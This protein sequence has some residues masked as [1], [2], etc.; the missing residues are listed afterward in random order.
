MPRNAVCSET[1]SGSWDDV[2][3]PD[4]SPRSSVAEC[5]AQRELTSHYVIVKEL[6]SGTYGKVLLARCQ[7]SGTEVA[8]KML[9]KKSSKL[10]VRLLQ[11]YINCFMCVMQKERK[12]C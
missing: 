3:K 9:A 12:F 11:R 2:M 8:L 6:G 5:L 10:K 1:T 4:C 7:D